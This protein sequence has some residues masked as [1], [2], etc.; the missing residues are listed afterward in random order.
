MVA[1]GTTIFTLGFAF[2][3]PDTSTYYDNYYLC[4]IFLNQAMVILEMLLS[5]MFLYNAPGPFQD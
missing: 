1:G 2:W 5:D 3:W 4:P